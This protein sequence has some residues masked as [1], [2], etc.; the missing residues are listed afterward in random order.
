MILHERQIM[1]DVTIT[2]YIQAKKYAAGVNWLRHLL[3]NIQFT[4]NRYV[5]EIFKHRQLSF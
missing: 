3:W 4:H 5:C 1:L 2:F